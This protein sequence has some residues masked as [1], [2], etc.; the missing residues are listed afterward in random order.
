MGRINFTVCLC[1]AI[2]LLMLTVDT[3]A[4][5]GRGGG[6]GGRG[7]RSRGGGRGGGSRGIR[8][9][10]ATWKT[11][12]VTGTLYGSTSYIRRRR[13][14]DSPNDEPE[15]CYNS[16]ER[17]KNNKTYYH[18]ICPMSGQVESKSHCCGD[19]NKEYCCEFFD[20]PGRL[21]GVVI[22]ILIVVVFVVITTVYLLKRVFWD[23]PRVSVF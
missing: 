3:E 14:V 2:F 1:L 22:A 6:R 21:A 18:F 17:D 8:I 9:G 10:G 7:G 12:L 11:A 15:I 19:D 13:Y 20:D 4:K 23:K 16:K 5:G